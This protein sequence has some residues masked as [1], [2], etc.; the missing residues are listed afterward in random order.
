[1]TD[2][3]G[4]YDRFIKY[5]AVIMQ[6]IALSWRD[7]AFRKQL[8]KN[9]KAALLR[10]FHY[11][12]PFNMDLEVHFDN[13]EWAPETVADWHI[14]QRNL[15]QMVLPPAPPMAQQVEALAAY[16]TTHLTFLNA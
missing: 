8:H 14:I 6:A 7:P 10:H 15:L 5:R 1:M 11:E 2:D 12:F 13:A 16:N 4:T 9:P 3:Y